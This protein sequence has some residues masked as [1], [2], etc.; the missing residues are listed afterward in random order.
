MGATSERFSD[1]LER[2]CAAPP[3]HLLLTAE[4]S[5]AAADVAAAM[6]A[7]KAVA[8]EAEGGSKKARKKQAQ[9][10]Q[11]LLEKQLV[12]A[13]SRMSQVDPQGMHWPSLRGWQ[14]VLVVKGCLRA[15]VEGVEH[16]Y[17][18]EL[19]LLSQ[20]CWP[21]ILMF[22]WQR[23]FACLAVVLCCGKAFPGCYLLLCL[24]TSGGCSSSSS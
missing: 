18:C 14:G 5:A 13:E 20:T 17:C 6:T 21:A 9:L 4:A 12:V 2:F 22:A 16:V 23:L 11:G 1:A 19:G 8:A 10:L 7:L 3:K 15:V 24:Q